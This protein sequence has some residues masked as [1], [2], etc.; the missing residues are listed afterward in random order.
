MRKM[1]GF[2]V[3]QDEGPGYN[4]RTEQEAPWRF[5]YCAFFQWRAGEK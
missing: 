4:G 1:L 3:Y 5:L 2:F